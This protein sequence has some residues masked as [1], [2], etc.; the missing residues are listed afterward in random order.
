VSFR[1]Y[2][3]LKYGTPIIFVHCVKHE[4]TSIYTYTVVTIKLDINLLHETE[5]I[6]LTCDFLTCILDVSEAC[7]ILI[8]VGNVVF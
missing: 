2:I 3:N 8:L 6:P 7:R 1:F 4:M 5:I